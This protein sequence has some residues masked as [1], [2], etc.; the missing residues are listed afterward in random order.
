MKH[1]GKEIW[2]VLAVSCRDFLTYI[3]CLVLTLKPA[4]QGL[5]PLLLHMGE[6]VPEREVK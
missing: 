5:L 1:Y 6:K 3:I 4:R 2:Y